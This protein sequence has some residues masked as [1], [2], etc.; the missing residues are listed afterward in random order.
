MNSDA[1]MTLAPLSIK[2]ARREVARLHR[3]LP[4]VVGGLFGSALYCGGELLGVAIA[5]EPKAR[6]L[7][8]R[9]IVEITRCATNGHKNACSKLYGA[10]CRAAAAIGYAEAITYTRLDE[11]GTSLLAAGFKDHGITADQSWSRSARLRKGETSQVRR[12]KRQ[13]RSAA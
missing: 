12:W 11:P 4:V 8:G 3:H 2:G 5:S 9:G 7:R 6:M 13:L 10:L 1:R